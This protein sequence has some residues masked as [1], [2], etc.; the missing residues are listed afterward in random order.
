[1]ASRF[2]SEANNAAGPI[3]GALL[4]YIQ[5]QWPRLLTRESLSVRLQLAAYPSGL[6]GEIYIGDAFLRADR[7][8]LD[9]VIKATDFRAPRL[10]PTVL[11][12]ELQEG[13]TRVG[14]KPPRLV[15]HELNGLQL[16]TPVSVAPSSE[17]DA[18]DLAALSF[19]TKARL[20]RGGCC[21][22]L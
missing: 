5:Q 3:T 12:F 14:E 19:Q 20:A 22:S 4:D 7:R 10:L 13:R 2:D 16:D 18:L 9:V 15:Q 21:S 1:M 11:V 8:Y 6:R 17:L